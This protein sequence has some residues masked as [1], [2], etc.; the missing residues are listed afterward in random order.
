M[1]FKNVE[2]FYSLVEMITG[3]DL[4][5]PAAHRLTEINFTEL[6][7]YVLVGMG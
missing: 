7:A 4:G 1:H 6:P 3:K 2:I 5:D